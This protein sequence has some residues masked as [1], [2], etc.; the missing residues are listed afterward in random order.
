[1]PCSLKD[2]V[3][4]PE[5]TKS[6][7]KQALH[8]IGGAQRIWCVVEAPDDVKVYERFFDKAVSILPSDDEEGRRSCRNVESIVS[9]LYNEERNISLLG[10][11]DC[12]YTRYDEN[13]VTPDHVFLTDCRDIEMMM[14][15]APSV[16]D[17]LK[18]WNAEFPGKI[19][20]CARVERYLG[21]L[22]I[23]NDLRQLSCIFRDKLTKVSLVWD[24]STHSIKSDYRKNLFDAFKKACTVNVTE[25]DFNCFVE[26]KQLEEEP[27]V[28]VCRGHDMFH[29]LPTMMIQQEYSEKKVIWKHMVESYSCSDFSNTHLY[30]AIKVWANT[31]NLVI[32]K[33]CSFAPN[34]PK[35]D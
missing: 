3:Q 15:N 32:F 23:Y 6:T 31:R 14:F 26:E 24:F 17:G 8:S 22:R 27:Y 13:Y 16:I 11:R 20:T 9:K 30:N 21:Y 34:T 33:P 18:V 28:N 29:L 10:I 5:C 7:I 1:M 12:D 35:P 19:E 2:I 25:E 4:Q